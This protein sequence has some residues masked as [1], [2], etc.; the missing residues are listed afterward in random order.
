MKFSVATW[1]HC[2]IAEKILQ[3]GRRFSLLH[4]RKKEG[5][6]AQERPS[7]EAEVRSWADCFRYRKNQDYF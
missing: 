2:S 7:P 1:F 6:V 5:Y 4:F 3:E